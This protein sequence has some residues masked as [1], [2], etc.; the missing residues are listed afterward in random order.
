M[1]TDKVVADLQR[2]GLHEHRRDR[3]TAALEVGI[4]NRSDR[5]AV[6]VRLQLEDIGRQDDGRQQVV[7]ALAG[8]RAQV[9]TLMLAAVVARDDALLGELLVHAIY[10]RVVLVDLV[11]RDDDRHPRGPRVVDRLDSLGH[12]AVVRGDD[13]HHQVSD[14]RAASPHG[15]ERFVAWR[16]DEHDRV[17]VGGLDLVG[18]NPLRDATRLAGGD[19]RLADRVEDRRL[20][21]V[22]VAEH[23][24]DG[25]PCLEL[26]GVLVGEAEQ[27]L[28]G[29]RHHVAL[30]FGRLD[31]HHV[32]ACDRLD[33][34]AELVGHDLG[35]GEVDDLVD[36][37]QDLRGHELLDHLDR[38]DPQLFRQVFDGQRR[39][40]D[41][42]PV[43]VGFDLDRNRGWLEGG[44]SG[45]DRA[46]RQGRGG[47]AGQPPLLEEVDQLLLADAKFA[48]EFVCLHLEL[49]IM[50]FGANSKPGPLR[51]AGQLRPDRRLYGGAQGAVQGP[52]FA[53]QLDAFRGGVQVR[54]ATR[55]SARRVERDPALRTANDPDQLALARLL[56]AGDAR[57]DRAGPIPGLR[58][59]LPPEWGGI[60]YLRQSPGHRCRWA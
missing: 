18:A 34:E 53:G 13:Q 2:P 55:R 46:G 43:A 22:D 12:H 36:R 1:A 11:D 3:A 14:L 6:G 10:V 15:G 29:G 24:H 9:H 58:P 23:G 31:R 4:H 50:P 26:G 41:G 28:A 60:M 48:R 33:R 8:S 35:G 25:R 59:G 37:G 7:D 44:A 49:L 21:V 32:L 20:A 30:A 57:P 16:V 27:L 5:V 42:T 40:E 54:A 17:P 19:A 45:L 38:A 39:G 47:V 52:P 51:A 56:P